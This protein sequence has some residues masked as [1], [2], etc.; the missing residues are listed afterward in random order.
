M[1]GMLVPGGPACMWMSPRLHMTVASI[2]F[3]SFHEYAKTIFVDLKAW[4][5]NVCSFVH[6]KPKCIT[7][8]G[9]SLNSPV[10]SEIDIAGSV[11]KVSG[12]F[13]VSADTSSACAC[14]AQTWRK[15]ACWPTWNKTMNHL[16]SGE[17]QMNQKVKNHKII[18]T[19]HLTS[20]LQY[21]SHKGADESALKDVSQLT[22]N[23]MH[24]CS[25]S[26]EHLQVSIYSN[27]ISGVKTCNSLTIGTQISIHA[28]CTLK[29]FLR[30][31][32][33]SLGFT[34]DDKNSRYV[35]IMLVGLHGGI[36]TRGN[37]SWWIETRHAR[38]WTA[39]RLVKRSP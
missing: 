18:D 14:A 25:V 10:I 16:L 12:A 38:D 26:R 9:P 6:R 27:G 39:L 29:E 24:Y 13:M 11:S 2:T 3:R 34:T 30:L 22:W 32:T 1:Q 4:L 8:R 7:C 19:V 33:C 20:S 31:L 21:W 23:E 15:Q 37:Q 36:F 5:N 35:Y 28:F 17:L